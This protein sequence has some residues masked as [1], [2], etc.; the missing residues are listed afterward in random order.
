MIEVIIMEIKITTEFIK[1][2]QLLK[3]TNLASSGGEIKF[4]LET[5]QILV[6]GEYDNRR[7]RKIYPGMTVEV[8]G[9]TINVI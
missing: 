6:D 9:E 8:L 1:L 3:L 4:I 7:G 5:E 2:G